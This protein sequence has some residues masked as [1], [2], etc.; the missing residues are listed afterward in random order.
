VLGV[1]MR[2]NGVES[3]FS[4][5]RSAKDIE[6]LLFYLEGEHAHGFVYRGQTRDYGNLVPSM[7]RMTV[8]CEKRRGIYEVDRTRHPAHSEERY[9][10]Q[11]LE[12]LRLLR[13]FGHVF[14]SALSQQY[15]ISS[16]CVDVTSDPKIAAFF[17]TTKYPEYRHYS[18]GGTGVIY[19]FP[20]TEMGV[21]NE[22]LELGLSMAA[23]YDPNH[24]GN[25][26]WY[27]KWIA[28]HQH[29]RIMEEN[30]ELRREFEK[31]NWITHKI[32]TLPLVLVCDEVRELFTD[33]IEE[34]G[35]QSVSNLDNTRLF[36]QKGGYLF[37]SFIHEGCVKS[38]QETRVVLHPGVNFNFAEGEYAISEGI[39]GIEDPLI[40][41]GVE[42]FYFKHT[43]KRIEDVR[44][45]YLWPSTDDD[46]LY[47]L[48]ILAIETNNEQ[49]LQSVGIEVDD[50][51]N[52]LIDRGYYR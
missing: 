31:Q 51:N 40:M 48:L 16:Q 2:E 36:R 20:R 19:R 22:T 12:R 18:S 44:A 5:Q 50:M 6:E 38:P 3:M 1:L 26:V 30:S 43:E 37:P 21:T 46:E 23:R 47:R 14:G 11:R 42:C 27:A 28:K 45:E 32:F 33:K 9:R 34:M 41:P 15:G 13:N 29:E 7:W 10:I 39:V 24:H 35:L 17:A 49:Y 52:G 25:T 4:K 8:V